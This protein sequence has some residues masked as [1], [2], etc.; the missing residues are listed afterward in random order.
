M[1]LMGRM[2]LVGSDLF[3]GG[4]YTFFVY[5]HDMVELLWLAMFYKFIR[6]P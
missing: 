4:F 3:D 2:G 1:G 6:Q 5:A